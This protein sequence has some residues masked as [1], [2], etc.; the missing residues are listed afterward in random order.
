[1]KKKDCCNCNDAKKGEDLYIYNDKM[2][3][4]YCLASLMTET[5][6]GIEWCGEV[7]DLVEKVEE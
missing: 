5:T 3:C 4:V 1:M 6:L 2:Y 7:G